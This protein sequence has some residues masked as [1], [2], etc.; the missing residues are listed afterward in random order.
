MR[1]KHDL[2]VKIFF[3]VYL[4]PKSAV[5]DP[6]ERLL[7]LLDRPELKGLADASLLDVADIVD[8]AFDDLTSLTSI[9]EPP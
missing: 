3:A 4:G 1:K 8:G 9:G 2:S 6:V 5:M 7:P